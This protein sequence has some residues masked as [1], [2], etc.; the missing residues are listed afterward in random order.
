MHTFRST[1]FNTMN[2]NI[3]Q[4]KT[5]PY[6]A[7]L[8]FKAYYRK[9]KYFF[10]PIV[11]VWN[12]WFLTLWW[13]VEKTL[14]LAL[15]MANEVKVDHEPYGL[16]KSRKLQT[17]QYELTE[18]TCVGWKSINNNCNNNHSFVA[19]TTYC[20][21]NIVHI[22]SSTRIKKVHQNK[23]SRDNPQY[24]ISRDA[25]DIVHIEVAVN[26]VVYCIVVTQT[27]IDHVMTHYRVHTTKHNAVAS[28]KI[29]NWRL[30]SQSSICKCKAI[31]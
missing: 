9:H 27:T 20:D 7:T 12:L 28:H 24:C 21:D 16:T 23:R 5:F 13:E 4:K 25:F 2:K 10:W 26:H 14:M 29:N 6:L 3:F 22:Q 19:L 17:F 11:C 31:F 8:F 30:T 1:M 15:V 18:L